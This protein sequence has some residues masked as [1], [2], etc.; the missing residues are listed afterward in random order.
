MVE[1]AGI[2]PATISS[3]LLLLLG[4]I[5]YPNFLGRYWVLLAYS[6]KPLN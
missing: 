2:E 5:Q 6:V 1:A 4:Y 3:N